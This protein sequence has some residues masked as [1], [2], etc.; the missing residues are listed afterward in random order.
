MHCRCGV[1]FTL[2]WSGWDAGA[3]RANGGLGLD[4]PIATD[5]GAPIVRRIREEFISGTRGGEL[6]AVP[7]VL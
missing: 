6:Q 4:A 2:V 3:P 7:A 5:N 1:G